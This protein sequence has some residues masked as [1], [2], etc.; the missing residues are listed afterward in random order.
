VV[1]CRAS[2][3][4]LVGGLLVLCRKG[5]SVESDNGAWDEDIEATRGSWAV[6]WYLMQL[7][8]FCVSLIY[9]TTMEYSS[10]HGLDISRV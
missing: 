1:A 9:G 3:W 8:R 6:V 4:V 10:R 5:F 7:L 2:A